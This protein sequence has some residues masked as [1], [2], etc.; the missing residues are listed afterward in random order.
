MAKTKKTR[1]PLLERLRAG[2]AQRRDRGASA[3]TIGQYAWVTSHQHQVPPAT[4]QTLLE[5]TE[6]D[7][8][9][10]RLRHWEAQRARKH[11]IAQET[12]ATEKAR[13]QERKTEAHRE[14]LRVREQSEGALLRWLSLQGQSRTTLKDRLGDLLSGA[15][16]DAFAAYQRR[17]REEGLLCTAAQQELG[18]TTAELARWMDGGRLPPDGLRFGQTQRAAWL[19]VWLPETIAAAHAHLPAWRAADTQKQAQNTAR[20]RQIHGRVT[21][22]L[23][24]IQRLSGQKILTLATSDHTSHFI[25]VSASGEMGTTPEEKT[26]FRR[27][28][29]SAMDQGGDLIIRRFLALQATVETANG[30]AL[31]PVKE[32]YGVVLGKGDWYGLRADETRACVPPGEA[33]IVFADFC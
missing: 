31:Y 22:L 4:V 8:F 18:C 33:N 27:A 26:R 32:L 19:K 2:I 24:R 29:A 12:C 9:T 15:E 28:L 21:A 5:P 20:S 23:N 16:W 7:A 6:W 14:L 11:H 30:T 10:V 13:A 25:E 17:L 1:I 3:D